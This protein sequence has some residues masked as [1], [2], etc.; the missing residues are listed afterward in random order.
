MEITNVKINKNIKEDSKCKAIAEITLDN[1]F[2]IHDI[3]IIEG[4]ERL[5]AAMPSRKVKSKENKFKDV[6]HPITKE[7]RQKIEDAILKEYNK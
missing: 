1:E 2:V 6:S 5:F 3:R 4:K 7:C